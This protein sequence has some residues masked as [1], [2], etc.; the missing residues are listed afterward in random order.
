M[1]TSDVSPFVG[2]PV[3]EETRVLFIVLGCIACFTGVVGNLLLL[4]VLAKYRNLHQRQGVFII[5]LSLSDL[6][7]V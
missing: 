4:T 7:I 5:N 3:E 2:L 6:V 1:N